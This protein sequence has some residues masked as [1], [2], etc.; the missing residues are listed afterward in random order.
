M[1]FCVCILVFLFL[2]IFPIFVFFFFFPFYF[3]FFDVFVGEIY[4][5]FYMININKIELL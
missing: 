5:I 2:F 3:C 1:F 4:D